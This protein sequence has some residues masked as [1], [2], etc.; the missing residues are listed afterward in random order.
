[1]EK[2]TGLPKIVRDRLAAAPPAGVHPGADLLAAFAEQGLRGAEREQVLLHLAACSECREVVALSAPESASAEAAAVPLPKGSW[3]RWGMLRWGAAAASLA[4]VAVAVLVGGPKM[5]QERRP[6]TVATE[7]STAPPAVQPA[8][9]PQ[10]AGEVAAGD[11]E[12]TVLEKEQPRSG[13]GDREMAEGKAAAPADT[14][15]DIGGRAPDK[16]A[17]AAAGTAGGIGSGVLRP[18]TPPPA[19]AKAEPPEKD[20]ANVS[21]PAAPARKVVSAPVSA[22]PA[23]QAQAETAQ[24]TVSRDERA[25]YS[26]ATSMVGNESQLRRQRAKPAMASAALRW[27]VTA[28]GQVQRSA[29]GGRSWTTLPIAS[30]VKFRALAANE[31]EVWAGGSRTALYHSSDA[32]QTWRKVDPG[33]LSGDIVRIVLHGATTVVVTTSAGQTMELSPPLGLEPAKP[34]PS[35]R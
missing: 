12:A 24:S 28:D 27:T 8:R 11:H 6:N 15:S 35:P 14:K 10:A 9:A 19:I 30:E 33:R 21:A 34:A 3:L 7:T 18:S 5:M 1:M 31:R 2:M 17:A 26:A 23:A 22:Q 29:D 16:A 4:I 32:G 13:R 25:A 20:K